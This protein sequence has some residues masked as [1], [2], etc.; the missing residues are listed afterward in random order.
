VRQR[1]HGDGSSLGERSVNSS[2]R[3]EIAW[4]LPHE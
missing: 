4:D 2:A 3:A 1:R